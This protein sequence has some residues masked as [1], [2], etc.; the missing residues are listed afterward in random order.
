MAPPNA[1]ATDP[2]AAHSSNVVASPMDL[3]PPPVLA[4]LANHLPAPDLIRLS[5]SSASIAAAL[6]S[7]PRVYEAAAACTLGWPRRRSGRPYVQQGGEG[8]GSIEES[9]VK[10]Q[11]PVAGSLAAA[12]PGH[13]SS[14]TSQGA[15]AGDE[16]AYRDL[17]SAACALSAAAAPHC[18]KPHPQAPSTG[19]VR[20]VGR[21]PG[22]VQRDPLAL[23]PPLVLSD[24]QQSWLTLGAMGGSTRLGLRPGSAVEG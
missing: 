21:A 17:L 3:L 15:D 2:P 6:A 13:N 5:I 22:F 12:N 16:A 9:S 20:S 23:S 7:V 18:L 1:A 10:Q 14:A 19:A 4:A 24:Q 11:Q 8:S